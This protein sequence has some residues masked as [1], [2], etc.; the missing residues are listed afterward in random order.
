M[1]RGEVFGPLP[2]LHEGGAVP[3]RDWPKCAICSRRTAAN[4]NMCEKHS[5]EWPDYKR[6]PGWV[7]FLC[8]EEQR[9]RYR[10]K[11]TDGYKREYSES[12][13][14]HI[15]EI[16]E[17]RGGEDSADSL[18]YDM[19]AFTEDMTDQKL[20]ADGYAI[21]VLKRLTTEELALVLLRNLAEFSLPQIGR[22]VG[23]SYTTAWEKW[24]R[25]KRRLS[26]IEREIAALTNA[27]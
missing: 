9:R 2:S 22:I 18:W 8:A 27:P 21:E 13:L 14:D 20:E 25:T 23:C 5:L 12:S 17:E 1:T 19:G 16:A 10:M 24:V 3:D 4:W 6:Q 26:E 11:H 15:L 7:K